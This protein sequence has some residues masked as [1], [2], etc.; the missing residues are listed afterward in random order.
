MSQIYAQAV[1]D[2]TQAVRCLWQHEPA[3]L[4]QGPAAFAALTP[5]ERVGYFLRTRAAL[6]VTIGTHM[7]PQHLPRCFGADLRQPIVVWLA[8]DLLSR[9]PAALTRLPLLPLDPR[10]TVLTP[11]QLMIVLHVTMDLAAEEQDATYLP[12]GENRA[13]TA[14]N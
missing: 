7:M 12:P 8:D 13:Q 3:L 1:T 4:R 5:G 6:R 10:A 2:F 14:R 9:W 11:L